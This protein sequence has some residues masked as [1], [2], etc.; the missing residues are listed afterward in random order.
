MLEQLGSD[1]QDLLVDHHICGFLMVD[2]FVEGFQSISESFWLQLLIQEHVLE[3]GDHSVEN[4]CR[5]LLW[6]DL[7]TERVLDVRV[8]HLERLVNHVVLV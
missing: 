1:L 4:G 6:I 8:A 3:L 2:L 5:D 7:R